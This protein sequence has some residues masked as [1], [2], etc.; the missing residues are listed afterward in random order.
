M[1]ADDA[2]I[3]LRPI[4]EEVAALKHLLQLIS[5][6]TGLCTNIHKSSVA[7]IRCDNLDLDDILYGFPAQ[8]TSFP[9]K[10]L[11][12]P[13][14]I[15]RLRRVD[16]QPLLDKAVGSLTGWWGRNITQAGRVTLTKA[17]VSSQSVFLLTSLN[18]PKEV[19]ENLDKL[20]KRFL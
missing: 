19:L 14:A 12:L 20:R 9:I 2:V 15:R 16:F 5:E 7:P 18:A 10:Y 1:Y 13:L 3:F 17:V 8:R 6:V 11:G 4:K